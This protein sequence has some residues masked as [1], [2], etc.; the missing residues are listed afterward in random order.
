V[1]KD[2]AKMSKSRGNTVDPAAYIE[3]YGADTVRLFMMF[4]APPEQALEWSDSG[5]EGGHRFL[6]R[7]WRQVTAHCRM[8]SQ[9]PPR[10]RA[11]AAAC[12]EMR[13]RIHA[14]IAKVGDDYARRLS[15]NTAIAANME[16]GNALARFA[17]AAG[18]SAEGRRI[19]TEGYESIVKMMAPVTP[20]IM[21][22]L[23]RRLGHETPLVDCAWPQ[24][25]ERAMSAE[26]CEIVV[27]VN[28][29]L[30]SRLQLPAGSG[31]GA[32]EEQALADEKVRRFVHGR[33]IVKTIHVENKLVN[34]VV[35]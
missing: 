21:H 35:R 30:R 15:F 31:R 10:A 5:V 6:K 33:E 23:W 2:G 19:L 16:L 22:C 29:R 8:R 28:G 9:P 1:L 32:V 18:D 4:A 11:D 7:F 20:H 24:A 3:R 13:R 17:A 27:Q 12:R 34:F 25:D 26:R 14:T